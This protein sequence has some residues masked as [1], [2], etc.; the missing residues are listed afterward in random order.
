MMNLSRPLKGSDMVREQIRWLVQ[1][2]TKRLYIRGLPRLLW[3][4]RRLLAP[5]AQNNGGRVAS[6]PNKLHFEVHL[7]DYFQWMAVWGYFQPE[8]EHLILSRLSS[9]CTFVDVGANVGLF[10]LAAARRVGDAGR[11]VAI[12][13]EPRAHRILRNNFILNDCHC[14]VDLI[15]YAISDHTGT[16]TFTVAKQIGHSTALSEYAGIDIL[17]RIQV[18]TMTL[19]SALESVGVRP[20]WASIIKIDVEGLEVEVLQ[21]ARQVLAGQ[22]ALIIEVN[23]DTLAANGK[24]FA[25]LWDIL[26]QAGRI[27]RWIDPNR[28]AIRPAKSYRLR[29]ISHPSELEGLAGDIFVPPRINP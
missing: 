27:I 22:A 23:P 7:D 5:S 2:L 21:G 28:R 29:T 20:E 25:H 14:R 1:R 24:Q 9:G 15:P 8:I 10:S 3:L 19:D 17:E 18:E 4:A 6:L 26:T 12:E 16:T 13:P 11:V